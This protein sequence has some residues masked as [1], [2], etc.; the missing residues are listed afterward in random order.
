MVE[1]VWVLEKFTGTKTKEIGEE[2]YPADRKSVFNNDRLGGSKEEID[3][4]RTHY[5]DW[6]TKE[7]IDLV[8]NN[9][10]LA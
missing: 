10:N 1:K 6:E 4:Y 7:M 3:Y 9:D 5:M 2:L 8:L